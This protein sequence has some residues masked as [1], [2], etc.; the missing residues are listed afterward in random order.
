MLFRLQ[1]LVELT[2]IKDSLEVYADSRLH[3]SSSSWGSIP[4]PLGSYALVYGGAAHEI[5][6]LE[7]SPIQ[8]YLPY[9]GI[10]VGRIS[11][12]HV[13]RASAPQ[14][15]TGDH[16]PQPETAIAINHK[17]PTLSMPTLYL[18]LHGLQ[19]RNKH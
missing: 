12:V 10:V 3:D 19:S 8:P 7:A 5:F 16:E 11:H 2:V 18:S 13:E 1:H 15:E 6:N 4:K 17:Q 9:F 14:P